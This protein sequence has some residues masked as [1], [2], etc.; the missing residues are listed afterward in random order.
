MENLSEVFQ[1]QKRKNTLRDWFSQLNSRLNFYYHWL[2][3]KKC[4]ENTL[5]FFSQFLLFIL[6]I[7]VYHPIS[8]GMIEPS[9]KLFRIGDGKFGC[10]RWRKE[11]WG[12]KWGKIIFHICQ[13][14]SDCVSFMTKI[15]LPLL[16]FLISINFLFPNH[17]SCQSVG[18][19][20]H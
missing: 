17:S 6:L 5:R 18:S 11:W 2:V 13:Y 19:S 16:I 4:L 14:S 7:M 3:V 10:S 8:N 1:K 12:G 9:P 20:Q 15:S